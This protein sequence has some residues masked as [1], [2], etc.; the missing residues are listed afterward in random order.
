MPDPF[1][2][3]AGQTNTIYDTLNRAGLITLC[4]QQAGKIAALESG[5]ANEI[6]LAIQARDSKISILDTLTVKLQLALLD[7]QERCI[8]LEQDRDQLRVNLAVADER[9]RL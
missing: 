8:E 3:P 7:K 6:R 9:L 1:D 2:S 5:I 4:E